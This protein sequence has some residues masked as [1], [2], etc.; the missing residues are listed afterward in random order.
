VPERPETYGPI[1]AGNDFALLT[2]TAFTAEGDVVPEQELIWSL[3]P[4]LGF[5]NGVQPFYTPVRTITDNAGRS[6]VVYTPVRSSG[7]MGVIVNLFEGDGTPTNNQLQTVVPND[8]LL[9]SE[10]I[11]GSIEDVFIFMVLDDDPFLPYDPLLREGGRYVVLYRWSGGIFTGKDE[12]NWV[13]VQPS[14]IVSL[15]RLVFEEGIP[16]PADIPNLVQYAVLMDRIVTVRASTINKITGVRIVSNPINLFIRIP[17]AQRGIYTVGAIEPPHGSTLDSATYLTISRDGTNRFIFLDP[18]ST[19]ST[20][21]STTSS[22]TTT[23]TTP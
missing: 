11:E 18:R 1:D 5:I 21:T 15:N 17:S 20:T 2:C 4:S 3:D 12:F 7:D 6:R 9:L 16:T 10:N 13:L 19:T 14:S 23:S 22:S 8:T